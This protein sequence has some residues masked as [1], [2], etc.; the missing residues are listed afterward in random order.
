MISIFVMYSVDRQEALDATIS[1]LK[2]MSLYEECQKT[3]VVDGRTDYHPEDWLIVE[4]PRVGEFCWANMWDAGVGTA[5]YPIVLYLDS[6]RLWPKNLLQEVVAKT[7]DGA[8]VFTTNHFL[9]LPGMSLDFCKEFLVEFVKDKS[10]IA[11]PPYL[12]GLRFDPRYGQCIH[13][14]GKNVMSGGTAFTKRTYYA[15]GG[16]DPW[17][18]GHGAYADTDFHFTAQM[19]GCRFVDLQL[20]ELHWPHK[21]LDEANQPLGRKELHLLSLDNYLYYC[22]K[23]GLPAS[24]AEG[25]A[26]DIGVEKPKQ[27]VRQRKAELGF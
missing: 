9:V 8:F 15:L 16:V 4:V 27:Y 6:D 12:G 22:N 3:L 10:V 19:A 24:F 20:P 21:K 23:W 25:V 7:T 13:A 1:C 17:Y 2:D 14:P 26:Y 11:G 5:R 18:A